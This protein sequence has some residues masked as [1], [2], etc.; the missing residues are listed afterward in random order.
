M[1]LNWMGAFV[2][3]V[4]VSASFA[5][6][7]PEG[8]PPVFSIDGTNGC[9]CRLSDGV[10]RIACTRMMPM[11]WDDGSIRCR[12]DYYIDPCNKCECDTETQRGT[13]SNNDCNKS[14]D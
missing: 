8:N 3:A 13:C 10:A 5:V 2:L 6:D 9:R 4:C 12:K 7:C 1:K 14:F 11:K